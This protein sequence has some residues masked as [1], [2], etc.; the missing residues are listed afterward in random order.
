[1]SLFE[2]DWPAPTLFRIEL[3]VHLAF[4]Q[5]FGGNAPL[6]SANICLLPVT[7]LSGTEFPVG[8]WT[9]LW[10]HTFTLLE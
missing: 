2:H 6:N 1:M 8:A 10:H 3:P 9:K 7:C 5:Y 4:A